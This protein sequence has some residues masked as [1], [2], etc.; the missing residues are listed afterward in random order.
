MIAWSV[1]RNRIDNREVSKAELQQP[2]Q[3]LQYDLARLA[4]GDLNHRSTLPVNTAVQSAIVSS[5]NSIADSAKSHRQYASDLLQQASVL[6]VRQ[7]ALVESIESGLGSLTRQN[8]THRDSFDSHLLE[9]YEWGQKATYPGE[10]DRTERQRQIADSVTDTASSLARLTAQLDISAG[11]IKRATA[12]L[13]ALQ[14]VVNDME[15]SSRE[16]S[17]QALNESIK[18]AG[19]YD[20]ESESDRFVENTQRISHQLQIAAD[21]AGR[22]AVEIRADLDACADALK[23][24]LAVAREAAQTALRATQALKSSIDDSPT[25]EESDQLNRLVD[26]VIKSAKEMDAVSQQSLPVEELLSLKGLALE[27]Q[28]LAAE[29]DN[30]STEADVDLHEVKA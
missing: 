20:V 15:N 16:S 13:K 19:Y 14:V 22:N 24:G 28:L 6:A 23:E 29:Y 17:L 26:S 7:Q 2:L 27:Q 3:M 11:R 1:R 25:P 9:L 4:A 10:E 21:Q 30:Q 8:E 18:L 5:F 12:R